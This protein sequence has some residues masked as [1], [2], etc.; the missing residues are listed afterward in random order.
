MNK[1]LELIQAEQN[2]CTR[3]RAAIELTQTEIDLLGDSPAL[4]SKLARQ[5]QSLDDS[6][7]KIAKLNKHLK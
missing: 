1:V 6:L 7:A 5:Q 3:R 4:Q 2:K